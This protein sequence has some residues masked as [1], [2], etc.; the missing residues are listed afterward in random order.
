MADFPLTKQS[1]QQG[2]GVLS[3]G[4]VNERLLSLYQRFFLYV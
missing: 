4:R 3:K 2:Q 1:G